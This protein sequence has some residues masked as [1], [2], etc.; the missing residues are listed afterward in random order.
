MPLPKVTKVDDVIW[1]DKTIQASVFADALNP[2]RF[3][4]TTDPDWNSMIDVLQDL[5]IGH[6]HDGV[7]SAN[8][9][10]NP[11]S[12]GDLIVGNA[13]GVRWTTLPKPTSAQQVLQ[14]ALFTFNPQWG[15]SPIG[16]HG[17]RPNNGLVGNSASL[18]ADFSTSSTTAVDVTGLT[19]TL[20]GRD[21][22]QGLV[23]MIILSG[24]VKMNSATSLGEIYIVVDGTATFG[25]VVGGH[26]YFDNFFAV[27]PTIFTTGDSASHTYKVQAF[28]D[29]AGETITLSAGSITANILTTPFTLTVVDLGT[30]LPIG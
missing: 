5:T 30:G 19:L 11:P 26:T 9:I 13:F 20:S 23:P 15:A 6:T 8:V 1:M 25:F 17:H 10:K 7:N 28:V 4:V 21:A 12:A 2:H 24:P 16:L 18:A 27:S 29:V 22:A 3:P 14:S